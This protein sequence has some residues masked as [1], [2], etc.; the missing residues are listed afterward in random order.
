MLEVFQAQLWEELMD[1]D[2]DDFAGRPT[3][4]RDG[5]CAGE[6]NL[7]GPVDH[8]D[9]VGC[10]R[11][12]LGWHERLPARLQVRHHGVERVGQIIDLAAAGI[13]DASRKIT[14]PHPI[15][16]GL[17]GRDG[18]DH[19]PGDQAQHGQNGHH[20]CHHAQG[21]QPGLLL[22]SV[23]QVPMRLPDMFLLGFDHPVQGGQRLVVE[24]R[25]QLALEKLHRLSA[26]LPLGDLENLA[27]GPRHKPMGGSELIHRTVRRSAPHFLPLGRGVESPEGLRHPVC[28]HSAPKLLLA[29]CSRDGTRIGGHFRQHLL[30]QVGGG[31][32][33]RACLLRLRDQR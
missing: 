27:P 26:G 9:R 8:E 5:G 30:L 31:D 17:Q 32:G 11:D 13:R 6:A 18:P 25:V 14:V 2:A 24:N 23:P 19:V 33:M 22:D 15:R 20:K 21:E 4:Q 1:L 7:S 3:Q 28:E 10:L 29:P 12:H 16:R